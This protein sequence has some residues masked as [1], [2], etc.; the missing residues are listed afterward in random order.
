M[1]AKVSKIRGTY[2]ILRPRCSGVQ[3]RVPDLLQGTGCLETYLLRTQNLNRRENK[4]GCLFHVHFSRTT[5]TL[6]K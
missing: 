4:N 6:L 2:R 1:T 5:R 3:L